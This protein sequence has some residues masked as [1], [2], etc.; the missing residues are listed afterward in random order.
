MTASVSVKEFMFNKV[1]GCRIATVVQWNLQKR[2]FQ[3]RKVLRN[4][5]LPIAILQKTIFQF[6]L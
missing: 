2:V 3:F 1:K 5:L 6:S 4:T